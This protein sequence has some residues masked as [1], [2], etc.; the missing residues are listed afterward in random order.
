MNTAERVEAERRLEVLADAHSEALESEIVRVGE[1][2]FQAVERFSKTE[3][4]LVKADAMARELQESLDSI[5]P[6]SVKS[7]IEDELES[8]QGVLET[9]RVELVEPQLLLSANEVSEQRFDR[10]VAERVKAAGD[11]EKKVLGSHS[12]GQEVIETYGPKVSR[13]KHTTNETSK[14]LSQVG[15]LLDRCGEL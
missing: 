2:Q 7:R 1:V 15:Q 4:R 11:A 13:C 12:A 3:Q 8:L 14:I 5:E 10:R 6:D 9:M